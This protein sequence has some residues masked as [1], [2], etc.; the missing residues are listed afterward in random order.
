V[1]ILYF[2]EKYVYGK[3]TLLKHLF[4][5]VNTLQK[6]DAEMRGKFSLDAFAKNH[7]YHAKSEGIE[8]LIVT[9]ATATRK[10]MDLQNTHFN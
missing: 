3:Y 10:S 9:S 2:L 7:A 1:I 4:Y 5:S 8:S 6:A